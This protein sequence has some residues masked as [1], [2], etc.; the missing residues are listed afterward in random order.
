MIVTGL[1][2]KLS[3]VPTT[4]GSPPNTRVQNPRDS[5]ATGVAAGVSSSSVIVRPSAART[6]NS[7]T[8]LA[9]MFTPRIRCGPDFVVTLPPVDR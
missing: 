1:S 5:I 7:G 3:V 9:V 8:L 2:L 6:P 4:L